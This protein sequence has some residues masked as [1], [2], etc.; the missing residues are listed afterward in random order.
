MFSTE[1][2]HNVL[3]DVFWQARTFLL[4]FDVLDTSLIFFLPNLIQR[5]Q[6]HIFHLL[7]HIFQFL[8]EIDSIFARGIERKQRFFVD[9]ALRAKLFLSK[10]DGLNYSFLFGFAGM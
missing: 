9:H 7:R 10:F 3:I 2:L 4:L 6:V 5:L 8:S 1:I